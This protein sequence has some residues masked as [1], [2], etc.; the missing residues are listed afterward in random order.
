MKQEVDNVT[1]MPCVVYSGLKSH[2]LT[3]MLTV[4]FPCPEVQRLL[5]MASCL[6]LE[7]C[8]SGWGGG[9]GYGQTA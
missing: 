7:G 2:R 4:A 1:P 8:K 3:I 6:C 5:G 9:G